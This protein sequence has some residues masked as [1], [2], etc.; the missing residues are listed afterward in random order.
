MASCNV[1]TIAMATGAEAEQIGI[2]VARSLSFRYVNNSIIMRAAQREHVTPETIDQVE[3]SAPL[4]QRILATIGSLSSPALVAESAAFKSAAGR[5]WTETAGM[6]GDQSAKYRTVILEI[7]NETARAGKVVI[8]AH[9]AGI[10]L[11]EMPGVLRTFVTGT[12]EVR[13]KRV[14]VVEGLDERRALRRVEHTD[15]ERRAFL[16][17]FFGLRR[18]LSTHYDLV[19][20]TDHLTPEAAMKTIV[21]AAHAMT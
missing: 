11:A 18:E 16:G 2:D 9:G 15:R 17:R 21:A 7:I 6:T 3:H 14:A 13:G 1:V 19:V 10:L 20:N 4:I 5:D 12:P 8:V